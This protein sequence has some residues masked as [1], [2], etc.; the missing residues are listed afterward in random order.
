[1]I[2]LIGCGGMLGKELASVFKA[3]GIPFTGTDSETDITDAEMLNMFC[4]DKHFEWIV[5]CSAY[6][7]VDKAEAEEQRAYDINCIG[8]E[9]IARCADRIGAKVIHFSTDYV[10]NGESSFPYKETDMTAPTS[11]YGRT[12]LA[13]ETALIGNTEKYFIFRI[14]WLYGFY[15]NN[16]VNTML[17]LMKE[18]DSLSVVSDQVGSPTYTLTLAQNIFAIISADSSAY[19]IYHY[20]DEGV[21]SWYDFAVKIY[22]LGNQYGILSTKVD[23]K[24]IGSSE[25]PSPVKRPAWSVFAKEKVASLSF[26]KLHNWEENLGNYLKRIYEHEKI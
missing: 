17:R 2:W 13:G 3:N 11:A 7:A 1:M 21:I 14:S 12:K 18:R 15:G 19:G 16:F 9:N 23:I 5:N 24:P 25:Y 6:T 10:F 20:S 4:R 22:Q 8:V 26:I